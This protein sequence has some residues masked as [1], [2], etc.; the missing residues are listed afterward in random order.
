MAE[1]GNE[2]A[3]EAMEEK[4]KEGSADEEAAAKKS[5]ESGPMGGDESPGHAPMGGGDQKHDTKAGS[6][7]RDV[8]DER[9]PSGGSGGS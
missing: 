9:D 8:G 6:K 3:P 2:N 7:V 4:A 5:P 1:Q